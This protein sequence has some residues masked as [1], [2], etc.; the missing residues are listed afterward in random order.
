MKQIMSRMKGAIKRLLLTALNS[1]FFNESPCEY[2]FINNVDAFSTSFLESSE[3][4]EP[5]ITVGKVLADAA[6]F[7]CCPLRPGLTVLQGGETREA[8]IWDIQELRNGMKG[9]GK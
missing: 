3:L 9:G 1:A 6:A 5:G 4:Q 2:G 8:T 7:K